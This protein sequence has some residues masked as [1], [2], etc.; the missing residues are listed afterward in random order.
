M[1][2]LPTSIV[3]SAFS[4]RVH[5]ELE[6]KR[7][8]AIGLRSVE[9]GALVAELQSRFRYVYSLDYSAFD[10]SAPA[11]MLDDVFRVLRTHL[12]LDEQERDVWERYVSDFIHSRI[13]TPDGTVFQKHRGIPS[14]SAFTS[15][16]G[17]VLNLLLVNYVWIRATGSAMKSDRALIQGDDV[18][19]ASDSRLE[20]GKL[21]SYAAELGFIVSAEKSSVTDSHREAPSPFENRVHFL[22]HYWHKGWAHRPKLEIL[23]RMVFT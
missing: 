15:I 14:G 20:L 19:F 12:E 5:S 22:G 7:P 21:A 8:F 11:F 16:V 4:K 3:G 6:R 18:I 17:S 9:K 10:S 2:P 1:A 13:I 23:Q